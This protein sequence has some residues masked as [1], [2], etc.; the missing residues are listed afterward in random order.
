MENS[1]QFYLNE[2]KNILSETFG[3]ILG[4]IS[5]ISIIIIIII[6][7][8]KKIFDLEILDNPISIMILTPAVFV[9]LAALILHRFIRLIP[10]FAMQYI[11][12]SCLALTA[13]AML[14]GF[15]I[16]LFD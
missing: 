7:I 15:I 14:I 4:I 13:L 12:T 2:I 11:I 6:C 10:S 1:F 5:L 8:L 9:G 3:S 16:A